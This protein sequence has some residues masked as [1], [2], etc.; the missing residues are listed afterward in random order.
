MEILP[1]T[2]R[3]SDWRGEKR[4]A[5]EPNRE[6]SNLEAKVAIISMAQQAVPNGIGQ[7]EF[8]PSPV[9]DFIN[10]RGDD[11]AIRLPRHLVQQNLIPC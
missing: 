3:R 8:F 1:E 2:I 11:V 4:I 5:S 6:R 10:R 7:R 9:D